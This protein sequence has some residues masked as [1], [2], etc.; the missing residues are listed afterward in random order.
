MEFQVNPAQAIVFVPDV[1]EPCGKGRFFDFENV[2]MTPKD[3]WKTISRHFGGVNPEFVESKYFLSSMRTRGYVHNLPI[4][5]RFQVLPLPPMTIHETL[6]QTKKYW[7]PWDGRQKL[8]CICR[9]KGSD[10]LCQ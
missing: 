4:E 5:G 7:P 8:N 3:V 2:A 10:I 6:P 1:M 9:A